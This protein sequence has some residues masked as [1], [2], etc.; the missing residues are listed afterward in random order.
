MVYH[1]DLANGQDRSHD[2]KASGDISVHSA[3]R[4]ANDVGFW[5]TLC[6]H[7]KQWEAFLGHL[8][9]G[10]RPKNSDRRRRRS[11]QVTGGQGVSTGTE[12]EGYNG[13][14]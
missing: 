13:L 3:T 8:P 6:K 1:N 11:E 14:M 7:Q 5:I 10:L 12:K 4:I 9:R 2:F